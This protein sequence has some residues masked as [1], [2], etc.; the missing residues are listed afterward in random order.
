MAILL[1]ALDSTISIIR[2]TL[3]VGGH[4]GHEDEEDAGQEPHDQ[5]E[6]RG[7]QHTEV[8]NTFVLTLEYCCCTEYLS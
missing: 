4:Q 3:G 5:E 7:E 2:T 8:G 6:L 1:S